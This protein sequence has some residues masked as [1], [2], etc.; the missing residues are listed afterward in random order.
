MD[1]QDAVGFEIEGDLDEDDDDK[2]DV[3]EADN[4]GKIEEKKNGTVEAKDGASKNVKEQNVNYGNEKRDGNKEEKEKK[5]TKKAVNGKNNDVVGGDVTGSKAIGGD[6]T[7]SDVTSDQTEKDNGRKVEVKEDVEKQSVE[8]A[9]L[10]AKDV[11][12][13]EL[14]IEEASDEDDYDFEDVSIGIG[15]QKIVLVAHHEGDNGFQIDYGNDINDLEF[16]D[17][18]EEDIAAKGDMGEDDLPQS[19]DALKVGIDR[20]LSPKI[21]S[22]TRLMETNTGAAN[23]SVSVN[24]SV[25][26]LRSD[27]ED[28]DAL[29]SGR[30][31]ISKL[32]S[33]VIL[34]LKVNELVPY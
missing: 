2:F 17:E 12:P 34:C 9:D 22:V 31:R 23:Q 13:E 32:D 6:V 4:V 8:E 30:E 15:D 18:D 20:D 27:S 5:G 3:F 26:S 7:A 1:C 10:E 25:S 11:P 19:S 16:Q 28:E 21:E 29:P 24:M 33:K 14:E